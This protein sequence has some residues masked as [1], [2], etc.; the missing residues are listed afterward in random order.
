LELV[1]SSVA[2]RRCDDIVVLDS[3]GRCA[4]TVCVGDIIHGVAQLTLP[5]TA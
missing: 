4:G 5:N 1:R 2:Y 3:G